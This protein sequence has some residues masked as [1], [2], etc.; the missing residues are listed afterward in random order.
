MLLF[1]YLF[2]ETLVSTIIAVFIFVF[3]LLIGNAIKDILGLLASNYLP[4][5]A[6][7]KLLLLIIPYALV[8]ALPIAFLCG[9]LISMGRLSA[10]AEI[11]AMKA[12]GISLTK[13][14]QPIFLI[15][16][17][18]S[19]L[20]L[21]IN[22]YYAPK[23]RT[24]Y[25]ESKAQILFQD[26]LKFLTEKTF[27]NQF[28]GYIIYIGDNINGKPTDIWIWQLDDQKRV[29]RYIHADEG[30]IDYDKESNELY[31]V[32]SGATIENRKESDPENFTNNRIPA[33][34]SEEVPLKLPMDQLVG[35]VNYH[36]KLNMMTYSELTEKLNVEQDP[37]KRTPIEMQIHQNIAMSFSTIAFAFIGI[38]FSMHIGRKETVVNV[39]IAL[40][41]AIV[42]Y[43]AAIVIPGW[44]KDSSYLYPQYL[45]WIPNILYI[46]LGLKFFLRLNRY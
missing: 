28:P 39:G 32:A 8:F 46:G 37:A 7:F 13:I 45:L 41:L 17:L 29:I 14:S 1:R 42:Y 33:F 35:K 5:G 4:I 21:Y 11:T 36:K 2:K 44:L 16:L 43:F 20:S 31:F 38:P 10:Q 12:S 9:V 30:K 3:V 27:I 15:A 34:R 40:V 22:F 23:T 19:A 26:P 24:E 6:F 25:K 18:C